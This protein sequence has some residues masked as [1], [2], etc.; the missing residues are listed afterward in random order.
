[1]G[2]CTSKENKKIVKYI[3]ESEEFHALISKLYE[4]I[5][6]GDEPEHKKNKNIR[7]IQKQFVNSD[8]MESLLKK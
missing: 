5:I 3:A 6:V 8:Y 4:Q 1:M 2:G 7:R